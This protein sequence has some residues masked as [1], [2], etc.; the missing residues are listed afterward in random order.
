MYVVTSTSNTKWQIIHTGHPSAYIKGS[1]PLVKATFQG[2]SRY[3]QG[4]QSFFKVSI[5]GEKWAIILPQGGGGLLPYLSYT[6]T[7]H[8]SRYGFSTVHSQ[9]GSQ[10]ERFSKIF[11]KQGVKIRHFDEKMSGIWPEN[12]KQGIN[13]SRFSQTFYHKQDQGFKVRVAPPHPNLGRVPPPPRYITLL[14]NT[15]T[16]SFILQ[17]F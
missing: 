12:H 11:Y 15:E 6:G 5:W 8:P 3:F 10:I 17:L 14:S 1:T 9:T 4:L 7:C 13:F 2:F 16:P